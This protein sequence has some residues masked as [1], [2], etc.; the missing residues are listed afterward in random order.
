MALAKYAE[1]AT[2]RNSIA[3]YFIRTAFRRAVP[4]DLEGATLGKVDV[5]ENDEGRPLLRGYAL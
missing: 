3:A 5:E 1:Q 2:A 4:I